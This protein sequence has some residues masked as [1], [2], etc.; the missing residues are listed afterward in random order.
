MLIPMK[1]TSSILSGLSSSLCL[2]FGLSTLAQKL[3]PVSQ[4]ECERY[5]DAQG[6]ALTEICAFPESMRR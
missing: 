3:D 1:T 4:G 2:A 6:A 5:P